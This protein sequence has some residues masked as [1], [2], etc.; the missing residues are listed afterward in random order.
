MTDLFV[1]FV[2]AALVSNFVL[3]Q[4]LGLCPFMGTSNRM[5]TAVPMGIATICVITISTV[6]S[7]ALNQFVLVPLDLEF[8]RII[9]F[10]VV[11]AAVVQLVERYVRFA[12]PL[13]HQLLGLYLPLI[14]S[15]CAVLGVALSV[16]DLP[17]ANALAV[18]VGA[19]VGFCLVLVLFAGL[20]VNLNHSSVPQA[21]QGA[22][23]A[24]IT[25]GLIA[26]AFAG[27]RGIF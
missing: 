10:I 20:R 13:L 5:E 18:G 25:V 9:T 14:T 8:L 12:S 11:I 21:F 26:L 17:L 23:I 1:L 16:A 2:G 7:N 6:V 19:G 22:P 27:F 24:L 4:L 15:N 3:V